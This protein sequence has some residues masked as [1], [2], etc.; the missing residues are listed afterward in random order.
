MHEEI[1][2]SRENDVSL[3][4]FEIIAAQVKGKQHSPQWELSDMRWT[5][6]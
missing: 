1:E 6:D 3:N 4:T 2:K 5:K